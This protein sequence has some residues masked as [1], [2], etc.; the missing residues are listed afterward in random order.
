LFFDPISQL[1]VSM[2]LSEHCSAQSLRYSAA[3]SNDLPSKG[4]TGLLSETA[5][6]QLWSSLYEI[7]RLHD[8]RPI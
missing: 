1:G 7:D 5:T 6:L 4:V 2:Q 3:R 8:V